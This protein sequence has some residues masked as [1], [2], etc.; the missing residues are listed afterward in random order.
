MAII[1]I[2]AESSTPATQWTGSTATLRIW[3][4]EQFYGADGTLVVGGQVGSQYWYKNIACTIASGIVTIPE[5]SL[6]STTDGFPTTAAYTAVFYDESG[7]KQ[8]TKLSNFILDPDLLTATE[9]SIITSSVTVTAAGTAVAQGSYTYRGQSSLKPYYTLLGQSSSTTLYAIV[10]TGS[11]WRINSS[12]GARYY[13]SNEDVANPWNVVTWI[14]DTGAAPL[15]AVTQAATTISTN[16]EAVFLTNNIPCWP[17]NLDQNAVY[18]WLIAYINNISIPWASTIASGVAGKTYLTKVPT[19][20]YQSEAVGSNEDAWEAVNEIVWLKDYNDDLAAAITAIGA[21]NVTLNITEAEQYTQTAA[22][23][24]SGTLTI[25]DAYEI[26]DYKGT[27]VQITLLKGGTGYSNGTY[28]TIGSATGSG[29]TVTVIVSG[30]VVVNAEIA[31]AGTN[32]KVGDRITVLDAFSDGEAT[33]EIDACVGTDKFQNCSYVTGYSDSGLGYRY[34]NAK[35]VV[36]VATATTPTTWTAS[37]PLMHCLTVPQNITLQFLGNGSLKAT[38]AGGGI[39]IKSMIDPDREVF[40]TDGSGKIFVDPSATGTHKAIWWTGEGALPDGA[41]VNDTHQ[42]RQL[43][44]SLS[45]ARRGGKAQFP[46]GVFYTDRILWNANVWI[47]GVGSGLDLG[48]A[49]TIRPYTTNATYT[50]AFDMQPR[51]VNIKFSNMMFDSYLSTT[52]SAFRNVL[53]EHGNYRITFDNIHFTN[54][55]V[56]TSAYVSIFDGTPEWFEFIDYVFN[57]CEWTCQTN[58]GNIYW[59]SYNN[60]GTFIAPMFRAGAGSI[61]FVSPASGFIEIINPDWRGSSTG[62]T[63]TPTTNRTITG[64]MSIT[65]TLTVMTLTEAYTAGNF[66]TREDIGR[67]VTN[68]TG[69][70][71][72]GSASAQYYYIKSITTPW[73]A[74]LGGGPSG[75]GAASAT[76]VNG[77]VV[78]I[79]PGP[80]TGTIANAC[81][82]LGG[83]LQF[84]V[85]GGADEGFNYYVKDGSAD[86]RDSLLLENCEIQSVIDVDGT[87]S[88]IT[89]VACI[90]G[91]RSLV[92]SPGNPILRAFGGTVT[93]YSSWYDPARYP[94]PGMELNVGEWFREQ[95]NYIDFEFDSTFKSYTTGYNDESALNSNMRVANIQMIDKQRSGMVDQTTPILSVIS[96]STNATTSKSLLRIGNSYFENANIPRWYYDFRW[97]TVSA[98]SLGYLDIYSNQIGE[99]SGSYSGLRIRGHFLADLSIKSISNFQGIGYG[100][101]AGGAVTQITSKSTSVTVTGMS[102]EITMNNA[103]LN[104]GVA[105][106]FRVINSSVRA[107]DVPIACLASVGTAGTYRVEASN[108]SNLTDFYITVTNITAGNLSEAIKLNFII[109]RGVSA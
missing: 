66:L 101:G 29:C 52:V 39:Y 107:G 38:G 99:A 31:A 33:L 36:F 69:M 24:T 3:C 45:V 37:T 70:P 7:A 103:A 28:A 18:A 54:S 47:E 85:M 49:T 55:S 98:N 42:I 27:V 73:S 35:G 90:V 11:Q 41:S 25:G 14:A 40:V 71:V 81:M 109:F 20:S 15:P 13:Y 68:P 61:V 94:F 88:S 59:Q 12:S 67:Y 74:I 21:T 26:Q 83:H 6:Q 63:L 8:N 30:G 92:V 16:W 57:S 77:N 58:T 32:Y 108:P 62:Y 78:I 10:W 43:Q 97:D 84:H 87:A 48:Y 102:G 23:Q 95:G 91:S 64:A 105:V 53:S 65:N 104:A 50:S 46:T 96:P 106:T 44:Q 75:N 1:T 86:Y 100:T 93:R 72:P 17:Y 82:D 89:F 56:S 76:V 2:S 22:L 5:V 9:D 4:S 80:Y 79:E 51:A 34:C 60:N 19:V